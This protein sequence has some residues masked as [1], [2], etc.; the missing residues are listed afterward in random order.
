MND[1]KRG[2]WL[3]GAYLDRITETAMHFAS[4]RTLFDVADWRDYI[5]GEYDYLSEL[6][7]E[8]QAYLRDQAGLEAARR[9]AANKKEELR[10]KYRR[11]IAQTTVGF[12]M[13]SGDRGYHFDQL[14]FDAFVGKTMHE[15]P[16]IPVADWEF[17]RDLVLA[18]LFPKL[19][20]AHARLREG[21]WTH[22]RELNP[23][24]IAADAEFA[25]DVGWSSLLQRAATRI[26]SYPSAWGAKIVGGKEKFGCLV[27]H[28]DCDYSARGCRSE[29]D[30]L[31][32]EIRL[33]SLATCEICGN[34]GR[35]R[36][37]S[38]AKT[39]CDTHSDILGSLRE[40]DGKWADPW[41]WSDV[42]NN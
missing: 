9:I 37:S 3:R 4:D 6:T 15:N 12:K 32:E 30:R 20:E 41:T 2:A 33:M 36:L 34:P 40:D 35:L 25:L 27:I 26:E 11:V 22:L 7:T 24:T 17:V 19:R 29:V 8:D 39:V 21:A 5:A 38:I 28:V 31:R 42:E 1:E 23:E 10:G 18:D 14:E 13:A 16:E